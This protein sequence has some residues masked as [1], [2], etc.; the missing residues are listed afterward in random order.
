MSNRLCEVLGLKLP[1]I[2]GGMMFV[3]L[4]PLVAAVSRAGGLGLLGAGRM[5]PRELSI[6]V[7]EIRALTDGPF[8]V[9]LPLRTPKVDQL[10]TAVLEEAVPVVSTSAGD[11]GRYTRA[12][13]EGGCKVIHVAAMVSQARKAQKAGVDAVVAEG[14]ESGGFLSKN[15]V[16]TLAL[17]PQVV[18]AVSVPVIAAGGIVD[19]RGVAASFALGAQGV[20]MG[21]RFLAALECALPAAYKQALLQAQDIDTEVM[22]NASGAGRRILKKELIQDA[23]RAIAKR[24]ASDLNHLGSLREAGGPSSRRGYSAG[25]GAGLIHEVLPADEIVVS[26]MKQA[27]QVANG[28]PRSIEG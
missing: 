11:P 13:R 14:G 5:T 4:P 25:Q 10:V 16:S 17:V 19:G 6:A 23:A 1:I 26:L 3:G 15:P 12:L 27:L 7:R 18:D 28:L 8:G 21:T 9:N 20:Q 2:L 24:E 22:L